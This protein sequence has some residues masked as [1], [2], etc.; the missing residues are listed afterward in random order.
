MHT[1]GTRRPA[2]NNKKALFTKFDKDIRFRGLVPISNKTKE[3]FYRALDVVMR[4][5]NKSG[6]AIKEIERDGEFK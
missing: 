5:H 2:N 3:E 6:F 4:N 1:F